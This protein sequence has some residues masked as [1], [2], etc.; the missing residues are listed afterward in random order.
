M[1]YHGGPRTSTLTDQELRA[2]LYFAVGVTSESGYAAYRLAVAGDNPRTLALEPA[3]NSGYTIGTIQTDLGQ[4]Y[5]PN[6]LDGENVPRD[7]VDAYQRWTR[8][9]QPDLV[10]SQAQADQAIA[11]LGRNGRA[12]RNQAGRPLDAEVQPRLDGY[13]ASDAGISW[14]H[15]RDVAQIDRLMDQ[16]IAPLQRSELYRNA[17]LD[18]QVKLAAMVGKAYNQ[19]E[20]RS[21]TM[22]RN[23]GHNQYHSVSDVSAAV[24]GL[25]PNRTNDYFEQGR[26]KALLGADVINALRNANEHSPLATAWNNVLADPLI[27]PTTLSA[28]PTRPGL[29]HE[30]PVVK[31]LFLH[32]DRAEDFIGALDR[33]GTYQNAATDRADPTRFNGAG[34]YVAGNDFV[35]WNRNG[36]GHAFLNGAWSQVERA[37]LSRTRNRDGSTDLNVSEGGQT[38]QLLHVDPRVPVL[39]GASAG[40]HGRVP[41]DDPAHQDHAMLLQIRAGV[42]QLGTQTGVP[43]DES[44][45]RL[46]RSL[47]A[48]C[49]DNRDQYADVGGYSMA[50]NALSRVHHVVAGP[51]HVFAVQGKLD[52]PAQLR[53][54][55]PVLQAMQTP[56][57]QSDAKLLAAN[58]LIAEEIALAQQRGFAQAQSQSASSTMSI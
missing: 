11:D 23:I 57:E 32:Y 7:L 53:A 37:D 47:L 24:D 27:D 35:S 56:V 42:Q 54:C 26:D 49:K 45:E 51:G 15:G 13:L 6:L 50:S 48:A 58:G 40:P 19:N 28:N 41:P 44:S 14:I 17:S 3:D 4:H 31:N 2:T 5:Q 52:D 10:L 21:V 34:F 33:G 8:V 25:S 39:R 9:N 12:I 16:A 1:R 29:R 36:E 30:Y 55:V 22:I 38:R 20:A 46:C 18:D 43:F